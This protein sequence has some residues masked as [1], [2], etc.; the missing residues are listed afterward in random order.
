MT[1][2]IKLIKSLL[3]FS[4][5]DDFYFLQLLKR[6]KDNPDMERDMTVIANYYIKS[7]EYLD[8]VLPTIIQQCNAINCRAYFRLNRR[9]FRKCAYEMNLL[10]AEYL[11]SGEYA[12]AR[13]L[14]NTIVGKYHADPD[15]KWIIDIDNCELLTRPTQEEIDRVNQ[16]IEVSTELQYEGKRE[17]LNQCIPSKSGIHILT[18]PFNKAKFYEA[19]PGIDLHTDNPVIL[20]C[21]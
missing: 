9:S 12:S 6:R 18:R 16:I 20:Y 10:L 2:N 14:F 13:S 11:K 3:E 7:H 15:P 8:G 1:D 4:S 5:P 19:L 21:P 17:P